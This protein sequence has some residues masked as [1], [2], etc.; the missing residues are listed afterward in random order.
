MPDFLY[1][2]VPDKCCNPRGFPEAYVD[3]VR[4]KIYNYITF[5]AFGADDGSDSNERDDMR[6]RLL[7]VLIFGE[8]RRM[9]GDE[10]LSVRRKMRSG[11]LLH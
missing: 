8:L 10:R 6:T 4:G 1:V 9:R 11:T 2:S 3:K 5:S 7:A